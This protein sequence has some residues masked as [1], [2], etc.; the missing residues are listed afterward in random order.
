MASA[1]KP[2]IPLDS[3]MLTRERLTPYSK[4]SLRSELLVLPNLSAYLDWRAKPPKSPTLHKIASVIWQYLPPPSIETYTVCL[5]ESKQYKVVKPEGLRTSPSVLA[6]SSPRGDMLL[7]MECVKKTDDMEFEDNVFIL[8]LYPSC[9]SHCKYVDGSIRL[10]DG[11]YSTFWEIENIDHLTHMVMDRHGVIYFTDGEALFKIAK[12]E[13][14]MYLDMFET[15]YTPADDTTRITALWRQ[16]NDIYFSLQSYENEENLDVWKLKP[17]RNK[18]ISD[19]ASPLYDAPSSPRS[20]GGSPRSPRSP[21]SKR[22]YSGAS[23][24]SDSEQESNEH[25]RK[26]KRFSLQYEERIWQLESFRYQNKSLLSIGAAVVGQ[27][28]QL[29]QMGFH[30]RMKVL[31]LIPSKTVLWPKTGSDETP[32]TMYHHKDTKSWFC[33]LPVK[34]KKGKGGL[35]WM[36]FQLNSKKKVIWQRLIDVPQQEDDEKDAQQG[37]WLHYDP[38]RDVLIGYKQTNS[39]TDEYTFKYLPDMTKYLWIQPE[40]GKG[41]EKE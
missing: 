28:P 13:G 37:Q 31:D 19:A 20:S 17:A 10:D 3:L 18:G 32:H 36:Q 24:G 25:C 30:S 41:K 34:D 1:T 9:I 38:V 27:R 22:S 29:L 12:T 40:K 23:S 6:A 35:Q 2:P 14:N 33:V 26:F 5:G 4:K 16:N 39:D 21:R 15:I 8:I 7:M 11:T